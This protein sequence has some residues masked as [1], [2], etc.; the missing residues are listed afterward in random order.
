LTDNRE[1]SVFYTSL[2]IIREPRLCSPY[3]LAMAWKNEELWF[4][5]WQQQEIFFLSKVFGPA[6]RL[7]TSPRLFPQGQDAGV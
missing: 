4:D 5:S 1:E 3:N 7:I 6:L 2:A